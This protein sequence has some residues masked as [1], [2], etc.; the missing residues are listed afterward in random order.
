MIRSAVALIVASGIVLVAARGPILTGYARRFIVDDP[1][2][3]DALVLL[4]GDHLRRT[5][6]V[7]ELY[8]RG[9]A[10][11]ILMGRSAPNPRPGGLDENE[12]TR[13][14]LR[15]A[16]VPDSAIRILPGDVVWSTRDESL[17]VLA[18]AA[19]QPLQRI[20]LVTSPY[21][22]ARALWI[23]RRTLHDRGIDVHAA[24]SHDLGT[25]SVT[26]Y[27]SPRGRWLYLVETI[28]TLYYRAAY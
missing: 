2:P 6:R 27:R 28:K 20:T 13:R 26:W 25:E 1:A 10:P 12:A 17:R 19:S 3:S 23:F 22:T 21:H 5:A 14:M 18:F 9:D 8:K 7:V 11:L 15:R 4:L 16:G 24:A